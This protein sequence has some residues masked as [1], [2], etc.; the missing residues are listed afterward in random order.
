[1]YC[2]E[3][4]LLASRYRRRLWIDLK[5][6]SC[7]EG[8]GAF[9]CVDEPRPCDCGLATVLL[10]DTLAARLLE[11]GAVALV[12]GVVALSTRDAELEGLI[13]EASDVEL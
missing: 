7:V 12:V 10:L 8:V 13:V 3:R 6:D 1:M 11:D 5:K 9:G 4:V 2:K